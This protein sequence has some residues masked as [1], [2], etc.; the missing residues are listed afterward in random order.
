MKNKVVKNA[1]WIIAG[2]IAQS[3]L[4]LIVSMLTARYLGPSNYGKISYAASIVAFVIPIMQ[5]G[6]NNIL[7]QEFINNPSEEG[8]IL[9]TSLLLNLFSSFAC[10]VGVITFV[11]FANHNDTET[12][13]VCALYSILLI[14]QSM[15]LCNYWFQSKYLSKYTSIVSLIAYIVVSSYK[16][17]LLVTHKSVY[18]FAISNALDYMLIGIF[19]LILYKILGGKRLE[20]SIKI[21]EKLFARSRYYIVSSLMVTIFAQTDKIMINQMINS[22]STGYYSAAVACAGLSSFIFSAI[23]DSFRPS[24]FEAK[25]QDENK[26]KLNVIRLYSIVIYLSLL[27]SLVMTIF[28]PLI[29]HILYGSQYDNSINALQIV[30]WYTTFSYIGSVRNIWILAENNQRYLWKINLSGAITNIVLNFI[31]IPFLGILGAAI[32]SLLTQIFT[33]VIIGYIIYDLRENNV[34]MLKSLNFKYIK[35]MLKIIHKNR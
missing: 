10:I 1:S 7:V 14:F 12:I 24:I 25:K 34:F 15:E 5:L 6:L 11:F 9:G 27:Q 28:A 29:I 8:K 19:S 35:E 21:G 4:G 23:I 26:Y 32:A 31:L 2:K 33:N 20:F 16:I 17:F 3:V 13:L 22:A 18:W 30:V